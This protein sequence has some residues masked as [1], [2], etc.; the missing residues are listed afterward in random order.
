MAVGVMI[1][2][3]LPVSRWAPSD[4]DHGLRQGQLPWIFIGPWEICSERTSQP[5]NDINITPSR[6]IATGACV[7]TPPVGTA[8][9]SAGSALSTPQP[10]YPLPHT[11]PPARGSSGSA[12]SL[13][14]QT[15]LGRG[16]C[17]A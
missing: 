6:G 2:V 1:P 15:G 9:V 3:S 14:A 16:F 8:T 4:R 11:S 17:Q 10:L 5:A 7:C 13:L 12:M